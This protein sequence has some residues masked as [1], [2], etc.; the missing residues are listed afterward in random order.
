MLRL[1]DFRGSDFFR[2][3]TIGRAVSASEMIIIIVFLPFAVFLFLFAENK[4]REMN[5]VGREKIELK[6]GENKSKLK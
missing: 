1:L 4:L 6:I 5:I 3:T 2:R